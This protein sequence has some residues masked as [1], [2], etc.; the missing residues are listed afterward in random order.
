MYLI[1]LL[2]S[3]IVILAIAIISIHKKDEEQF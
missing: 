2:T 3:Y 1:F